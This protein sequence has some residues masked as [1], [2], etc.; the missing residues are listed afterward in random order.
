MSKFLDIAPGDLELCSLPI[1]EL[2]FL[3]RW[4]SN[5][6]LQY[7]EEALQEKAI[8]VPGLHAQEEV[9]VDDVVKDQAPP[10][11]QQ[12]QPGVAAPSTPA[13]TAMIPVPAAGQPVPGLLHSLQSPRDLWMVTKARGWK[14]RPRHLVTKASWN[15]AMSSWTT[16]CGWNFA[17]KSSDFYF[18]SGAATDKLKCTKC[19]ALE[20]C[21][22]SHKGVDGRTGFEIEPLSQNGSSGEPDKP[23]KKRRQT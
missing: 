18:V 5:V 16:A 21:A 11:Q 13:F 10:Q 17:L 7:A 9:R 8:S 19:C 4:K 12:Q 3:G 2:A 23:R 15:L 22:T 1:Q 14:G 6:V 20:T